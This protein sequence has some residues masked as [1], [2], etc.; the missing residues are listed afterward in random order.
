MNK[1]DLVIH[2]ASK[3]P[4]DIDSF[5]G[6][7]KLVLLILV[8]V[9]SSKENHVKKVEWRECSQNLHKGQPM[10]HNI[11]FVTSVLIV[12]ITANYNSA[13]IIHLVSFYFSLL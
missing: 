5:S 2:C 11:R 13:I 3:E 1:S 7:L 4:I 8:A 12:A 9:L 6:E 10:I